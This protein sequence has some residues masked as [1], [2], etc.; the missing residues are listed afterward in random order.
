M[1]K[2]FKELEKPNDYTL[3]LVDTYEVDN[4]NIYLQHVPLEFYVKYKTL[5]EIIKDLKFILKNL[6]F[7]DI[8]KFIPTDNNDSYYQLKEFY[9]E[10]RNFLLY[11]D[12]NIKSSLSEI[13]FELSNYKKFATLLCQIAYLNKKE[14]W[15]K[16]IP[17]FD[18]A[19]KDISDYKKSFNAN[20]KVPKKVEVVLP[21]AWYITSYGD[22]YNTGCGHSQT[23]LSY[24]IE[25]IDEID[26]RDTDKLTKEKQK[27]INLRNEI[28]DRGYIKKDEYKKYL[29]LEYG[30]VSLD[31]GNLKRCYDPKIIKTI[32]GIV[33]AHAGFYRFFENF[34]KYTLKPN[35]EREK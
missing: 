4:S 11:G 21:N 17:L 19:L 2:Y 24:E 35:L 8:T 5:F 13:E 34:S 33:S 25:K 15:L 22:L 31:N 6:D 16:I 18:K 29:N 30:F 9:E 10:D 1:Y 14:N 12:D 32:Y 28:L 27:Y 20:N 26:L 3:Q 23:N 7:D